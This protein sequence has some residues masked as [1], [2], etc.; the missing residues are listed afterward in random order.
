MS[1]ERNK[2]NY[3]RGYLERVGAK[4]N[5]ASKIHGS[6]Q[7]RVKSTKAS[8]ANGK[9]IFQIDGFG[10]Y[11]KSSGIPYAFGDDMLYGEKGA[12]SVRATAWE[13]LAGFVQKMNI[14]EGDVIRVYG[15][16]KKN[17]WT[18]Q[19]GETRNSL[20]CTVSHVEIDFRNKNTAAEVV[21]ATPTIAI[22]DQA[23]TAPSG[24]SLDFETG[25]LPF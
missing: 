2:V 14:R 18:G 19:S 8:N 23:N 15:F 16:F 5:P 21:S 3:N 1:E 6:I 24:V 11:P 4:D 7:F 17:T 20:D 12:I 9:D 10:Y 13:R 22:N 25:E